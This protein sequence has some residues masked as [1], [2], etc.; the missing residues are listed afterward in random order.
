VGSAQERAFL[1]GAT[2]VMI[3]E[4][5]GVSMTSAEDAWGYTTV[6]SEEEYA[7]LL[8]GLFE[9]VRA[10][11]QVTGFCYTQYMDTG[12]ETNGLLYA[13]GAPK[14]PVE[15]VRRIVTGRQDDAAPASTGTVGWTD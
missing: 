6:S 10:S 15:T 8:T 14:L 13:D 9:A 1:D 7:A 11:D 12:Q 4:F 3:T 5:G 2:P